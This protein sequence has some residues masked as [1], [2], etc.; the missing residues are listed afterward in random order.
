VGSRV[1]R[2]IS[3]QGHIVNIFDPDGGEMLTLHTEEKTAIYTDI[4]GHLQ[5]QTRGYMT[6]LRKTIT[7]VQNNP[8]FEVRELGEK[9][10]D[11]QKVIGFATDDFTVWADAETALPVR[12][13]IPEFSMVFT[14]FQ[15][16]VPVEELESLV[17]MDVP[18]G[19]T[20]V[21][22]EGFDMGTSTEQDLVECLRFWAEVLLDGN[23]P[24]DIGMEEIIKLAPQIE[25]KLGELEVSPEEGAQKGMSL[26]KGMLFHMGL[27]DR[28]YAGSGVK[29]GETDKAVFW[30][31]PEGSETYR[32]IYGD[33]SVKDV[34]AG[35]LPK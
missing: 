26:G 12:V 15:F 34:A 6:F 28:H 1:R 20:L 7:D 14:N 25:A 8:D 17:S 24:E 27:K 9:E 19:Y 33:L 35:D 31:L 22:N 3:A 18:D 30:Y 32:V 4:Q 23:F 16:N 2:V 11:G 29:V 10:I 21:K 13:E 5:E